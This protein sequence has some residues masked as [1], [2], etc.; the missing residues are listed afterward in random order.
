MP[1]SLRF[2]LQIL[3]FPS[4]V[5]SRPTFR[6]FSWWTSVL[7]MVGNGAMMFVISPS[8][9][10]ICIILLL[11]LVIILH[12]HSPSEQHQWGSI[13]Q[14]LIFHQ[15]RCS[16]VLILS[17]LQESLV[18]SILLITC[19]LADLYVVLVLTKSV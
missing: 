4:C 11:V 5:Y 15:V 3:R 9:A 18:I 8:V 7:G 14:A 16:Y 1:W 12:L 19:I 13:S 6:Y 10:A 2:V 17:P